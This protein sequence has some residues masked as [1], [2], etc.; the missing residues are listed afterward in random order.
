MKHVGCEF[1]QLAYACQSRGVHKKRREDF[2]VP[3][4]RVRVQ[5]E[6][7]QG[8]FETRAETAINRKTRAGY[9]RRALKIEDPGV[10]GDFPMWTRREIKFWRSAPA[11]HLDIRRGIVSD[12]D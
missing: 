7:S 10:L 11:A 5:K 3:V 9:F 2:C 6:C 1:R 4:C 12:R 8:A